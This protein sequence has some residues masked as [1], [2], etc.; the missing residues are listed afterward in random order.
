MEFNRKPQS[1]TVLMTLSHT[2]TECGSM[3]NSDSSNEPKAITLKTAWHSRLKQIVGKPYPNIFEIVYVIKK[4]QAPTEMK[5]EQFAQC[6]HLERRDTST[7][8]NDQS[9][10]AKYLASFSETPNWTLVI[11]Q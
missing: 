6:N 5:L 3:A 9:S 11:E 1:W 2:L 8:S 7:L 10:L 4:E